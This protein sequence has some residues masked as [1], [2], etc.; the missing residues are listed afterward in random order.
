MI[1]AIVMAVLLAGCTYT[2]ATHPSGASLTS[3]RVFTQTGASIESTDFRA[4]Y[5][6]DPQAQQV[7]ALMRALIEVAIG[8]RLEARE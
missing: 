5:S 7:D 6:S 3:W 4:S 2:E 8:P 1:R